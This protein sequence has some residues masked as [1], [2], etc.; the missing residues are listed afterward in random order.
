MQ[1]GISGSDAQQVPSS[2][3]CLL[4]SGKTP[5]ATVV[6]LAIKD[7]GKSLR[8]KWSL[9]GTSGRLSLSFLWARALVS[10]QGK[11]SKSFSDAK[12]KLFPGSCPPNLPQPFLSPPASACTEDGGNDLCVVSSSDRHVPSSPPPSSGLIGSLSFPL[13][14]RELSGSMTLQ[15][16]QS[17]ME[18]FTLW[19]GHLGYWRSQ[20]GAVPRHVSK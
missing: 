4:E 17:F 7:V 16:I 9:A 14:N 2:A 10:L 5:M 12:R 15:T 20:V 13:C 19:R 8:N 6:T 1:C 11:Q 18:G 3:C